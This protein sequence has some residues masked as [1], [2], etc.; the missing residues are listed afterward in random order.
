MDIMYIIIL[1]IRVFIARVALPVDSEIRT[2][3][4][5][6]LLAYEQF[7]KM[8]IWLYIIISSH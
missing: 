2:S 7:G 3:I 4:R 5:V 1:Y 6:K 8:W